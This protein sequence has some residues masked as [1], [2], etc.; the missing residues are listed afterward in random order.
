MIHMPAAESFIEVDHH[1]IFK[2]KE[3]AG[4]DTF[5]S[6]KNEN[7]GRV[8]TVLSDGLGSGIK[9]GVLSTL[10]ATMA[11]KFVA[12]NIP[13]KRA[14]RTIMNTLP[15]CRLREISYATFTIVDIE[16][17]LQVR[18]IEFDNPGYFLIRDRQLFTPEKHSSIIERKNK[19]TAP[20]HNA[21]MYY[22]SYHALPGDRLVFFSDGVTQSGMGSQGFPFGWG[23]ERVRDFI[24][25]KIRTAPSISARELAR[26]IVQRA[27]FHDQYKAKDDITC[28]VIY[29]R[30]PRDLL[31]VTGPPMNPDHDSEMVRQFTSF[32]GSRIIAGGTT[33]GIISRHTERPCRTDLKNLDPVI[34]PASEME[35]ADLVTEGIITLGRVAEILEQKTNIVTGTIASGIRQNAADKIIDMVIN[36]DRIVFLV[37]TKINEAHQDPNMPVGLEIRRNIVKKIQ[38]LLVDHYLKE[39]SIHY[40]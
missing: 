25:D 27:L 32:K 30:S 38:G 24:L 1:Q 22:S 34:P 5:L 4:G 3:G 11:L 37:G 2:H 28:G 20:P 12:S 18:I 10:T 7:D 33:A 9:A 19:K 17:G 40:L 13:I 21:T 39:V 29:I 15:V 16:P 23:E 26:S 35:G 31:I 36:H 14:A 8:I 6:Q